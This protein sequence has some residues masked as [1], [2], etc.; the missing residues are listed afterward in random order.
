MLVLKLKTL[1]RTALLL[2]LCIASQF[3]KNTSVY[4]TGP[5]I[6]AILLLAV[7]SCGAWSGAAIA[8]IT[9][10]TSWYIT[11]SPLMTALPLIVPCVMGGNLILVLTAALA[12]RCSRRVG[13]LAVLAA[14][15]GCKAL[16]MYLT[17]V[18]VI[19]PL[20]GSTT[21]L[22]A[23]VFAAARITFSVTQLLT[24]LIGSAVVWLIWP[25]LNRALERK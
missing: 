25:R 14:G 7:F 23:Q 21:A 3:L 10:L 6:N 17:I 11:G 19:F 18:Q 2:A 22:P 5:I 4:I 12:H 9:P 13:Q 15:S 24:A 20:L 16:F 1:L 8:L